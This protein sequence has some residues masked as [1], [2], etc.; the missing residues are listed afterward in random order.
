MM[1]HKSDNYVLL[2]NGLL[3]LKTSENEDIWS[4]KYGEEQNIYLEEVHDEQSIEMVNGYFASSNGKYYYTNLYSYSL[5]SEEI[6]KEKINIYVYSVV[7]TEELQK[8]R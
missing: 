6:E 2:D 8:Q 5:G 3:I 1:K 4:A 7:K